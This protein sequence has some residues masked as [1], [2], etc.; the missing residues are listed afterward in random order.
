MGL[1][2]GENGVVTIKT[3]LLILDLLFAAKLINR[4]VVNHF[5]GL[6]RLMREATATVLTEKRQVA[7]LKDSRDKPREIGSLFLAEA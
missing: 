6:R 4:C 3:I 7:G 2:V 1:R 5:N